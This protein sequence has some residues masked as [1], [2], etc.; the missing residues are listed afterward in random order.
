MF[1]HLSIHYPRPGREQDLVAS[2]HRFG[3]AGA[4][5]PGFK[6]AHTLRDA[7]TGTLV[8]L[9][10]WEDEASWRAGV[11]AMRTV[12]EGDPFAEWEERD[13]EVL[14]LVDV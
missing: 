6:E 4:R 2:M 13:P 3:V 10:I 11:E 5:E 9:A 14:H 7:T 8:G 1:V 12:V